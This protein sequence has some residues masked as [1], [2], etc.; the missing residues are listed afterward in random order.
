MVKKPGATIR[1]WDPLV[2][3]AHWSLLGTFTIA[4]L[5]RTNDYEAHLVTGYVVMGLIIVRII[6]GFVGPRHARYS[7]FIC[8]PAPVY[9]YLRNLFRLTPPRY[10]GHNPAGAAMIIALIIV[11]AILS[12]SGVALDAAENR[13]GPLGATD[14]FLHR[15]QIAM[16]HTIAT[17]ATLILVTVHILGVAASSILHQENLILSM[18][19]GK[20]RPL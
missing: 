9:A 8:G 6:W 1:I 18:I 16:V 17:N 13:A 7:D 4:Y 3:C 12:L 14:L 5:T 20:K 2:R 11:L 15:N 10:L 19:T